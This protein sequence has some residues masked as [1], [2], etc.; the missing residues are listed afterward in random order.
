MS[1]VLDTDYLVVGGGAS[2]MAFADSLTPSSDA[3]VVIVEGGRPLSDFATPEMGP[4]ELGP[5]TG[6]AKRQRHDGQRRIVAA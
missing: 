4:V 3:E 2:G 5:L 6:V 1:G